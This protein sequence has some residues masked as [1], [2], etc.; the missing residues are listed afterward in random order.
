MILEGKTVIITGVGPGLGGETA[1]LALR[2]GADIVVAARNEERLA[3][4]AAE[5]DAE[6]RVLAV[7]TDITDPESCAALAAAATARF[8]GVDALAQVAARDV[9]MGTLADSTPEDFRAC[10]DTNVVGSL[11]VV[12]AVRPVLE[13]RG[14]GAIVLV[15]S[16]SSSLPVP[17]MP[18][19]AYATSKGALQTATFHLADELGPERIRVN[20]V[21][22][23]WMWGPPV[24]MYVDWKA[25]EREVP[26]EQIVEEITGGM[27]LD[28]VP[29]DED[30][31][32]AIVWLCSDRAR[33]ITGQ[34]LMVN[35][36]ELKR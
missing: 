2:D 3:A 8:G 14:G 24:E 32:E 7:P 21:V 10:F 18:Q 9:V 4:F 6:D 22:P 16:Q 1:R 36:G 15:G 27:S 11:N 20:L 13:Q 33:M 25:S 30:V 5:L 35:A 23:T 17:P 12:E 28:E 19:I 31:A 29:A 34:T 26:K